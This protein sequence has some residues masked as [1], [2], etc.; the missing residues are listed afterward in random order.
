M[1]AQMPQY[2]TGRTTRWHENCRYNCL[3]EI[4]IIQ[5]ALLAENIN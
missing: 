5:I 4:K 2:E 1:T 3:F